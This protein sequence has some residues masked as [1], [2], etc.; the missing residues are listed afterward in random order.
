VAADC[1]LLPDSAQAEGLSRATMKKIKSLVEN[2]SGKGLVP[3]CNL[4]PKNDQQDL[5]KSQ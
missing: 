2:P 3:M 1:E 5:E 4:L